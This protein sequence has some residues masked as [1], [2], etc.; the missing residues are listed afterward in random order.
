MVEKKANY[1]IKFSII[2]HLTEN[3]SPPSQE[4]S[5]NDKILKPWLQSPLPPMRKNLS[6]LCKPGLEPNFAENQKQTTKHTKP[7]KQKNKTKQ[8]SECQ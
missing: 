6:S 5:L 4:R 1:Q 2:S 7:P 3:R 8:R